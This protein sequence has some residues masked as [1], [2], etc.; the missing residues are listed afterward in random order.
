MSCNTWLW[1]KDRQQRFMV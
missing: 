1:F